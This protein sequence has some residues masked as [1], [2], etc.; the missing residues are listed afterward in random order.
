M[1]F[2]PSQSKDPDNR[3]LLL[4]ETMGLLIEELSTISNRKWEDLPEL[5]KKK[6]VLASRF[7]EIDWTPSPRPVDWSRLKSQ[8]SELEN[9]SRQKIHGQLDL[10][11]NQILALQELHQ[12]WLECLNISFRKFYEPNPSP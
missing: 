10:I 4:R 5:K 9:H 1:P 6:V 12:Y 2:Q 11:D 3:T 7:R 8:I